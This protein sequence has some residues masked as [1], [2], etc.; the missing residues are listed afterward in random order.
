MCFY[1]AVLETVAR[2]KSKKNDTKDDKYV[3]SSLYQIL[4]VYIISYSVFSFF[5]F[6]AEHFSYENNI[7]RSFQLHHVFNMDNDNGAEETPTLIDRKVQ[8]QV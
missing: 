3:L 7:C 4:D 6:S 5:L 1:Q 8:F 2:V